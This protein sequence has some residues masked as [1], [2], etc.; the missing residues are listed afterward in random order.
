VLIPTEYAAEEARIKAAYA[1]RDTTPEILKRESHFDRACLFMMQEQEREILALLG[2]HGR[3]DL[4]NQKILEVGCGVGG[5]LRRLIKWGARPEN[6]AGLDLLPEN[7]DQARRLSPNGVSLHIGNAANIPFLD[8]SFDLVVQVTVFS[9]ILDPRMKQ[10]IAQEMLRVLR[11]GGAI[12]WLDFFF[13]NPRNPDVRGVGRKEIRSLFPDCIVEVTRVNLA[14][15]LV[16]LLAPRSWL[17]CD[18]LSG[19]ALLDTHYLGLF[20]MKHES[21]QA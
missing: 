18:F 8:G 10:R 12:L 15:P 3:E 2:R 9:S 1:H 19:L 7:I 5:N 4:A 17:L 21:S 16:R 20:R 11:A 6:V 13:N 14:P